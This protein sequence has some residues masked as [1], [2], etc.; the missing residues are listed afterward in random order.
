MSQAPQV[1]SP[2]PRCLPWVSCLS[3]SSSA[4][5]ITAPHAKSIQR[6]R[7]HEMV[8][9]PLSQNC[10][11]FQETQP[12]HFVNLSCFMMVYH[13]IIM[14][15]VFY[16]LSLCLADKLSRGCLDFK[17]SISLA[18]SSGK[19]SRNVAHRSAKEAWNGRKLKLNCLTLFDFQPFRTCVESLDCQTLDSK[20]DTTVISKKASHC[21]N[22][23]MRKASN[24]MSCSM[25]QPIPL[26]TIWITVE[27]QD[28]GLINMPMPSEWPPKDPKIWTERLRNCTIPYKNATNG[29]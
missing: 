9:V 24:V 13:A 4:H 6:I 27:Q 19:I 11:E 26:L 3:L 5:L 1:V 16:H 23:F 12:N 21:W 28:T 22:P 14:L 18:C 8:E 17:R 10:R 29:F 15:H 2:K 20:K 25:L 7:K